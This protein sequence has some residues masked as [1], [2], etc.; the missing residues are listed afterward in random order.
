MDRRPDSMLLNVLVAVPVDVARTGN[1]LPRDFGKPFLERRRQ[2]ARRFGNNFEAARRGVKG[3]VVGKE[4]VEVEAVNKAYRA[5][6]VVADVLQRV[7]FGV[8]KHRSRR[9]SREVEGGAS[10]LP[11]RSRQRNPE[12]GS[13]RNPSSPHSRKSSRQ[14][15]GR[16]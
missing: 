5:G 6:N 10:R 15:R 1:L 14:S 11:C 12:T 3:L 4:A 13:R 9:R 7:P 8:R 16:G 2:I